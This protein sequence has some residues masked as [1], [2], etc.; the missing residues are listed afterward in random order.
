MQSADSL[1]WVATRLSAVVAVLLAEYAVLAVAND[2]LSLTR[3]PGW[4]ANLAYATEVVGW[5]AAGVSATLLLGGE[6]LRD[7]VREVSGAPTPIR[8]R[9][10]ALHALSLA[11]FALTSSRVFQLP[12]PRGATAV[13]LAGSWLLTGL[14]LL[15][16]AL[17]AALSDVLFRLARRVRGTVLAGAAFGALV[18]LVANKTLAAWEWL[19]GVTLGLAASL[20]APLGGAV[21]VSVPELAIV[22]DDF[23]VIVAPGCS[24][25]DG[26]TL[27]GLFMAGYLYR[28]RKRCRFPHTLLLLPL[29]VAFAFLFNGARIAA[30]VWVG[31]RVSPALGYGGFHSKVGWLSFCG[32]ALGLAYASNRLPWFARGDAAGAAADEYENPTAAFCMP[33]LTLVGIGML[34]NAFAEGL[35][36][37]YPLRVVGAVAVMF[38]YRDYYRGLARPG[39]LHAVFIGA[40]VFGLWLLFPPQADPGANAMFERQLGALPGWQRW[41]WLGFRLLGSIAVVPVVEELAF[42]G[43]LQRRL[44]AEDFPEVSF[45]RF[46]WLSLGVTSAVFGALHPNW[47]AGVLAGLAFAVATY[48]RGR[49]ADAVFAHATANALLSMWALWFQRWELW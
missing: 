23:G 26:M 9:W 14:L 16:A 24:G 20:L 22:M 38:V 31:A 37:L 8:L 21:R 5:V 40:I 42:R 17:R 15:Y 3:L 36:L 44:L 47:F 46:S 45:Q 6:E 34:T 49:L 1:R 25:I 48:V 41:V 29:G 10:I 28:F 2:G 35:D 11:A 30:L 19:S 4:W 7:Q 13:L 32:L 39:S 18:S 27:V 33:M 43:Y 12:P